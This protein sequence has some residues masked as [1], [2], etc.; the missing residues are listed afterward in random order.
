M[1]RP[2]MAA[3][4]IALLAAPSAARANGES[5]GGP[6]T[7]F[8]RFVL[9]ACAPCVRETYPVASLAT[10]PLRLSGFPSAAA[11]A[12]SRPGQ[13]LI[14]VLRAQQ[15]G[16]RDWTSLALRVT[17][18]VL[19]GPGGDMYRLG[20]GLL[21]GAEARALADAVAEMA[22]IGAAAPANTTAE[23][24]DIDF[25]GGSLRVGVLRVRGETIAYLQA[26]DLPTLMQ[27]AI[28]EVPTTFYLSV[29]GLSPLATALDQAVATI[30]KIRGN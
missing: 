30:E 20:S 16:R 21:D 12:A 4:V 6:P 3:L 8:E 29:A 11:A 17:L 18:S 27:R 9:S 25:H 7:V 1:R 15:L 23:V 28:W 13:I 19:A 24:T 22:R 2:V 5:A 14:E 26:G 10:S